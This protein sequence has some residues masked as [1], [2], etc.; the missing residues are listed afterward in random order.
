MLELH[1]LRRLTDFTIGMHDSPDADQLLRL[2]SDA[3]AALI[4]CDRPNVTLAT[5][6]WPT[7][8]VRFATARSAEQR[9]YDQRE[10]GYVHDDPIYMNRLRL[11]SD[12]PAIM[13]DYLDHAALERST[14]YNEVWR[15]AGVRHLLSYLTPA[16]FS[17]GLS[18]VRG[19]GGAASEFDETDRAVMRAVA[20]NLEA[21][22]GRIVRSNK[23]RLRTGDGRDVPVQL[24]AWIVCDVDGRVLRASPGALQRLRWFLGEDASLERVPAD[25]VA[26]FSRRCAGYPAQP[27]RRARGSRSMS[28]H[29]APIKGVPGEFTV[30]FVESFLPPDP[31]AIL[32]DMGLTAREAEV[33]RWA[34]DGKSSPETAVILGIST[35][36][37][38]KHMENIRDALG[39]ENR[40]TAVA[41]ALEK[42]HAAG[43]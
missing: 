3:L 17:I 24:F 12:G 8:D 23:G 36:T 18:V 16:T 28:A 1:K 42:L 9:V 35:L 40:T 31:Q 29:V 14:I 5:T 10:A 2:T 39:V 41:H 32:R 15:G 33:L 43:V 25:W 20:E 19:D 21:A 22:L 26:E 38:R 11:L 27:I 4:P 13:S 6:V 34:I 30:S 37:V 7:S